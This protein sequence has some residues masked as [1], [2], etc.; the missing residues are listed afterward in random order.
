MRALVIGFV[1]AMAG[2]S[3]L[4]QERGGPARDCDLE[5]LEFGSSEP[6]S[7]A[8]STPPYSTFNP[9]LGPGAAGAYSGPTVKRISYRVYVR[10]VGQ[11]RIKRIGW[12]VTFAEPGTGLELGRACIESKKGLAPNKQA[13]LSTE[14]VV[15]PTQVVNS[16]G[17][18]RDEF[19][20]AVAKDVRIMWIE[21][22]D[23]TRWQR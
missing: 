9:V 5:I 4:A 12:E 16:G 10:N 17:Y 18:V 22:A 15:F 13:R 20:P 23:G 1:V 14:K 3:A 7:P 11:K 2:V 8:V 19:P 6:G 21:Y